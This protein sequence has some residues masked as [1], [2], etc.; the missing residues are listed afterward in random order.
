MKKIRHNPS[1]RN[2]HFKSVLTT[3]QT[4]AVYQ[5]GDHRE[6]P[7]VLMNDR[8]ADCCQDGRQDTWTAPRLWSNI[9][10]LAD[11][12]ARAHTGQRAAFF[13]L[14]DSPSACI[15]DESGHWCLSISSH[16]GHAISPR[17]GCIECTLGFDQPTVHGSHPWDGT[18]CKSRLT[19]TP[20]PS[21]PD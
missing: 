21:S 13:C 16:R 2:I 7:R 9:Q 4:E 14:V 12:M 18:R 10:A 17:P 5:R 11:R 6:K 20:S 8:P 19:P 1:L 3:D 15:P